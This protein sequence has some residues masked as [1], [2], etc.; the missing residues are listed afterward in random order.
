MQHVVKVLYDVCCKCF[1]R[2]LQR[3]LKGYT[4]FVQDSC[5]DCKTIVGFRVTINL[6]QL[7]RNPTIVSRY[8]MCHATTCVTLLH[9][10]AGLAG[11]AASS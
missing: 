2:F 5:V 3:L 4:I 6:A 11:T 1:V 8:Y 7:A 9:V 10:N